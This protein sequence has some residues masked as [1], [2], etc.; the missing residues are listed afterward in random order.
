MHP[1]GPLWKN[2]DA[3]AWS[4]AKGETEPGEDLLAAARRE[5]REETGFAADGPFLPLGRVQQKSGKVVHAWACAADF[6]VTRLV[7]NSFELEWPPRSGRC[8][9]FPEVDRAEYF[10]LA[11]AQAKINPAQFPLL[12]RLAQELRILE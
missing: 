10:S 4:I 2:K 3:G 1:G 9:R 7:S 5:L 12:T 6:D 11:D 8:A